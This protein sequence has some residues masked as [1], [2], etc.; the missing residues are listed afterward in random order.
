MARLRHWVSLAVAATLA[1]AC[2]TTVNPSDGSDTQTSKPS[3]GPYHH[4][5]GY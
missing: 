4:E 3:T 5:S 2:D 1:S